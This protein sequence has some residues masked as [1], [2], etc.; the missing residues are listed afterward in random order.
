MSC[1]QIRDS[2]QG[3]IDG[4]LDKGEMMA[5][6]RHLKSCPACRSEYRILHSISHSLSRLPIYEP[7]A[8]FN[9]A[10]FHRL[11][12]EYQPYRQP[13][14]MRLAMAAGTSLAV[15]WLTA[16]AVA[17]PTFLL[18]SKAYKMI[19][20]VHH[21]ENILPSIQAFVFK[22]GSSVYQTLGFAAKI[23]GWALRS[24]ALPAQTAVACLLALGLI[25]IATR[26]IRPRTSL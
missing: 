19:E 10:V 5:V 9:Q 21:P 17:L 1:E 23:T 20:W 18:N 12:L 8:D 24:S 26:G 2:L 11:G 3:L 25:L 7:R 22:V 16:I 15:F 13:L 6:K 14:W 4:A